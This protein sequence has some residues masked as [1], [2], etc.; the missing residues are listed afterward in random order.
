M[1]SRLWFFASIAFSLVAWGIVT[2]RY[3]W[4]ALRLRP[5]AEALRPLLML[6]AFRFV[7]LAFLVPGVVS[8]GVPPAFAYPAAYGDLIAATLALLSLWSLPRAAGVVLAWIFGVWGSADLVN[9]FYQ[10][11]HSGLL[12]GQL[13]AAYFIPTLIVPLLLITHG[14]AFRILLQPRRATVRVGQA[15]T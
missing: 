2:A 1:E 13:G 9:A 6:H 4:P 5:R 10:A 14:L 7:G 12:P 15:I 11:N 8:P 3:V